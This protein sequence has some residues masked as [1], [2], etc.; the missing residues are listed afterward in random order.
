VELHFTD[1]KP[2]VAP[3]ECEIHACIHLRGRGFLSVHQHARDFYAALDSL[4]SRLRNAVVRRVG[5]FRASHHQ[6]RLRETAAL[7]GA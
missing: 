7:A 4:A 2:G 1:L 6:L 5:K 3:S